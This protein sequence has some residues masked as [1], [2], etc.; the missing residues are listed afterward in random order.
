MS[1]SRDDVLDLLRGRRLAR[2]PIFSGLP[3][4]TGPGL[5]AKGLRFA[6]AHTDA[7]K[8]A[9][10]AAS[11]FELF[12]FESAV[13]PFD[14]CVEAEAL[15]CEV[16]FN[17]DV[18]FIVHPTVATRLSAD[19][20]AVALPAAA[21]ALQAG[22]LPVVMEAIRLLKDGVGQEIAVGAWIPGPFTLAW[23]IVE[24]E[25]LLL[26]IPSPERVAPLLDMLADFLAQVAVG[27]REAGADFLTIHE[28]GGSPQIVGPRVFRRLV[29]PALQRL[30]SQT[31]APRVLSVCGRTQPIIADLASIGAEAVSV[32]HQCELVQ[33]RQVIGEEALLFGNFDP[34]GLLAEG[35]PEAIAE[36]VQAIAAA[37]VDAIWPGCDLWPEIPAANMQSLMA[38][39]R[40]VRRNGRS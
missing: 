32:D 6:E 3:S 26:A 21:E 24:V 39:G 13:V 40:R 34:V 17:D 25:P 5:Q 18:P 9:A 4:L 30:V 22:R 29:L 16:N 2:L 33:A 1:T 38:S 23:Q 36:T 14:L 8:M 28:M 10:A 37:G 7:G 27:Y 15:G 31:P 35:T 12:G 11:T 20:E 19:P